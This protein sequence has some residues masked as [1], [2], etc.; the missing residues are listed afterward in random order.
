MP[1]DRMN[2][3][4]A[5]AVLLASLLALSGCSST[6]AD[7]GMPADAPARQK[8]AG[9]YLPVHDLP[10]DRADP[11]IK[12]ADQA[13]IEQELV[14]ARERQTQASAQAGK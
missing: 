4:P 14:A 1:I 5:A 6:I 8:D 2:R 7:M 13:K 11:T 9:G 10:P 3:G 12:P